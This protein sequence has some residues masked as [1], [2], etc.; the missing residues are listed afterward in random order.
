[1]AETQQTKSISKGNAQN[2]P[3]RERFAFNNIDN[4][5][6]LQQQQTITSNAQDEAVK[7]GKS[8]PIFL[9]M[10]T[11]YKEAYVAVVNQL[12]SLY[13]EIREELSVFPSEIKVTANKILFHG[14]KTKLSIRMD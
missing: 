14:L 2:Q 6:S 10:P 9:K 7:G 12:A 11:D 3:K 8:T 5:P 13:N 1:M 4:A